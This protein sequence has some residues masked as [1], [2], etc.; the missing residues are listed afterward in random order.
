M[1]NRR[2]ELRR[3]LSGFTLVELVM[4][5]AI[6]AVLLGGVT[7]GLIVASRAVPDEADTT[8][9]VVEAARTADSIADE[10]K[11][12]LWVMEHTSTAVT[13]TVPDRNGDG[14]PERI[15]YAWGGSAGNP[16]TRS[17]N[18][19]T[20]INVVE[21]VEAFNLTYTTF[22]TTE[23]YPGPLTESAESLL[24]SHDTASDLNEE[25]VHYDQW[26]AQYFKPA[27]PSEAVAW[28]V[29][30]VR[31]MAK[32]D[33]DELPTTLSLRL[34]NANFTP[35]ETIVD[36]TSIDPAAVTGD[37]QWL[38]KSFT[39]AGGLAPETGLCITFTANAGNTCKLRVRDKN[40]VMANAA[41][42]EGNP[43]WQTPVTNEALLFY[44][45]GTH[46][47]IGP[48]QTA[49]REFIS[50]VRIKLQPTDDAATAIIT[51]AYLL[52]EPEVLSGL[53]ELAFAKSPTIDH[54]GDGTV[55]WSQRGG[56][57]FDV[58]KLVSRQWNG[59]MV[60]LDSAP[61]N[62]FTTLITAE[63]TLR[64]T[65]TA[66][67]GAVVMI[68]ADWGL[69]R[70][71]SIKASL[72]WDGGGS[73]NLAVYHKTDAVTDTALVTKKLS[74]T[75]FVTLRLLID[76]SRDT[77]NVKHGEQDLGTY[78][79]TRIVPAATEKFVTFGAASGTAEFKDF[80]VRVRESA[81]VGGVVGGGAL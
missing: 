21:S 80:S 30:R 37:H 12:A 75:D 18:G 40:V 64:S 31:F 17:Y 32:D 33:N 71:A 4:S 70:C 36:S 62:N 41:W 43:D 55:D 22:T 6:F 63:A 9:A 79:Y 53:W 77:V 28:R 13:F 10:M 23:I 44:V 27:L 46:S 29:T 52:N 15:R 24:M 73:Q 50:G 3:R 69:G 49:T 14:V 60:L 11:A 74:T 78:T 8:V 72:V 2:K 48:D 39:N 35:S 57:S 38:E 25:H 56:G 59:N 81:D 51:S 47:Y 5:M 26:W 19:G 45:Y 76:P 42:V 67:E 7:A 65:S 61:V 54:N 1:L 58:S 20:A 34:P 68:N 66:G 16:L